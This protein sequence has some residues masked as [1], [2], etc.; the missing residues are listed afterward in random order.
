MK[1]DH[2]KLINGC[3]V[4]PEQYNFIWRASFLSLFT[5]IYAFYNGY[6]DLALCPGGVFITSINYWRKPDYSW[7]RNIDIVYVKLAISYQVIRAY[8]AEYS[9]M[10]YIVLFTG[11]CFYPLGI[12]LYKKDLLWPSIYAHSMIHILGNVSNVI[13]YSGHIIPMK[14]SSIWSC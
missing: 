11:L 7:R 8:N 14:F 12:Y 10:Y 6:Y 3:I 5:S 4:H 1:E 9:R 2:S 13:L